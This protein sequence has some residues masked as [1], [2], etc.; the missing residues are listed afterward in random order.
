M[1]MD[2]IIY[3]VLISG[4]VMFGFVIKELVVLIRDHYY[5]K[6]YRRTNIWNP[7]APEELRWMVI[8]NEEYEG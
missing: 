8:P 3:S 2:V 5:I 4:L 6:E 1:I 7:K